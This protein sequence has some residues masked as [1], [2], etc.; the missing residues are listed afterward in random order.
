MTSCSYASAAAGTQFAASA[1]AKSIF[2][3]LFNGNKWMIYYNT[4]T[5]VLHWDFVRRSHTK[6]CLHG[7]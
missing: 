2:A 5:Q 3:T 4:L 6:V 1:T 7:H